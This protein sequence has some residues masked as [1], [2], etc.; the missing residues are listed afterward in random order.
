MLINNK[1]IFR[2]DINLRVLKLVLFL[3]WIKILYILYKCVY[4]Y[5]NGCVYVWICMCLGCFK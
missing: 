4:I 3:V 5:Y 1:C 2:K